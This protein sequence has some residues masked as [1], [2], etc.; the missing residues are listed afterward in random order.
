MAKAPWTRDE[1]ELTVADYFAMLEAE[2]SGEPYSKAAHNRRLQVATGRG[3][4]S[5]EFKHQNISAVLVN[6]RQP[7]IPGYLPLQ[8]YQSLLEQAVLEWLAAHPRYFERLADGPIV[9]PQVQ[10]D[11][12]ERVSLDDIVE[13]PPERF[14]VVDD[15]SEGE[16]ARFYKIDFV[17]RDAENRRLGTFGE[18]FVFEF[19]RRRLHDEARRPDLAKRVEWIARTRGDGA[20]YDIASFNGDSTPRLIEVKTTGLGKH[21]PFNVT[22]N[23]VKVSEREPNAYHLYRVFDYGRNPHLY[24]LA[25]PLSRTCDLEPTQFRARAKAHSAERQ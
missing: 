17:R 19:E 23:E 1:V 25:G 16:P 13:P 3:R 12:R 14:V 21:F 11:F 6:F 5:I 8:N 4:G 10:Q 9:R 20:G 18:E 22:L 2:L 24:Q 15:A 7:F